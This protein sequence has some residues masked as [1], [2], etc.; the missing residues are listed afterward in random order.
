[1]LVKYHNRFDKDLSRIQDNQIVSK[2]F[3]FIEELEQSNNLIELN[4]IK[5]LIGFDIYYRYKI[6][7]YRIWF[8]YQDSTIIL[9]RILHRKDIYKKYPS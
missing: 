7:D 1:M 3:E 6:W 5:K 8:R 9:Y 4:N 2:V